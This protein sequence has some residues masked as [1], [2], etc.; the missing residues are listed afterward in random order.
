[1]LPRPP[2]F[3]SILYC[4]QVWVRQVSLSSGMDSVGVMPA[5]GIVLLTP[6]ATAL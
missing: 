6:T 4:R 2:H 1:M 5:G 3:Y